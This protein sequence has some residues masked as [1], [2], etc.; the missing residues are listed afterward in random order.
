MFNRR[1]MHTGKTFFILVY[2]EHLKGQQDKSKG[3]CKF[4]EGKIA[5]KS[6]TFAKNIGEWR[7]IDVLY[8]IFVIQVI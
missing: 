1:I 3:E 4:I 6:M 7:V 8:H 2:T 5:D